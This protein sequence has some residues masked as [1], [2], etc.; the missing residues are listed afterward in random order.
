MYLSEGA[1]ITFPVHSISYCLNV[2]SEGFLS[3]PQR[4]S[5]HFWPLASLGNLGDRIT[6]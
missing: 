3:Q 4:L 5:Y 1:L 2:L 6:A